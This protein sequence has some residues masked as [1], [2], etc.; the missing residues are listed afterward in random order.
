MKKFI[1]YIVVIMILLSSCNDDMPVIDTTAKDKKSAAVSYSIPIDDALTSL[2]DFF[3]NLNGQSK[4]TRS[5]ENNYMPS[6]KN[7]EVLRNRDLV[8]RSGFNPIIN[9]DSLVYIVNFEN[10]QGYALLSADFRIKSD[11]IFVADTGSITLDDFNGVL[12]SVDNRQ[13]FD[14]YPLTGAGMFYAENDTTGELFMNPNTFDLYN[15]SLSDHW[16][17]DFNP[18]GNDTPESVVTGMT[19]NYVGHEINEHNRD[20]LFKSIGLIEDFEDDVD[21]TIT[22]VRT[23][24]GENGRVLVPNLFNDSIHSWSQR[25]P[26]NNQAPK[27]REYILWGEKKRAAVGCVPLAIA[28]IMT[29]HNKPQT[30]NAMGKVVNWAQLNNNPRGSGAD[31]AAYLLRHIGLVCNALYFYQGTFVFPSLASQFLNNYGYKNVRYM[32]Y[33]HSIVK[34]MLDMQCPIFICSVPKLGT[35][36]YDLAKSHAWNLDGYLMNYVTYRIDYYNNGLLIKTE[37]ASQEVFMVHCDFGW[38]GKCNGYFTSGVF[39]FRDNDVI[40]DNENHAGLVNTNYNWYLKMISYNK[41][42]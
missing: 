5:G 33:N 1:S 26:F 41:P 12:S 39:D 15:S 14:E 25:E 6:I 3:A 34:Q 4:I 37:N 9:A 38:S 7:I 22:V 42:Y 23:K 35:L 32:D 40:F 36:N 21:P 29:Y 11:V 30:F 28:K 27:V 13:I 20:S 19:L 31:D 18:N 17:G 24:I 8:T 2:D 10:N 16:V